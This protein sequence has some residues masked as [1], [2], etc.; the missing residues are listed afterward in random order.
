[1]DQAG[2]K[3]LQHKNQRS[4]LARPGT[5]G[6][7]ENKKLQTVARAMVPKAIR[8]VIRRLITGGHVERY[9]PSEA[10][11]TFMRRALESEITA[12]VEAQDI[13]T[14]GWK[15]SLGVS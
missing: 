9:K 8:P 13:P 11:I 10:E 1:M 15:M 3:E 7:L 14:E 2:A 5:V 4:V 12:C 6:L